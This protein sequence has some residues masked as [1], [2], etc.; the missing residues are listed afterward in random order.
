VANTACSAGIW[1]TGLAFAFLLVS[2]IV[3]AQAQQATKYKVLHAFT[4]GN[5]GG[6]LWGSLLLDERGDIYGTTIAGGTKGKGGTAFKLTRGANGTWKETVLYNFCSL[7]GCADGGGSFAGLI[8]DGAGNLYGTTESG[9]AHVYGTVFRL[10]PSADGWKETLLHSFG[11]NKYGCCPQASLVM[12]SAGNLF[13]TASVAFELS[14]G[15]DGWKETV[16][17]DFTGQNGDGSGAYTGLVLDAAGNLYGVTLHGGGG[18]C[19]GGCGTAYQLQPTTGGGWEEHILH[20]FDTG[21]DTMAFPDGPLLPGSIGNL[22]G[23]A[24]VGGATGNGTVYRLTL[25]SDGHWKA[26][27]LHS[28]TGG[29]NGI[30][31]AAG[32]VMDKAGNLYG[33]TNAGGTTACGCGLI[34]KLAPNSNGKWT[35]TVLHR[36]TGFDGAGPNANLIMDSKGSLYGTTTTGGAGGN[37]VA[38]ELA[39]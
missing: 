3:P 32:V 6:G 5:D 28:F 8:F 20:D 11:F 35:Y 22:Y 4:G 12:D 16:L 2:A 7:P 39:P 1:R 9:G 21:G 15:G 24:S 14:T 26:T 23:T 13:G 38:F 18:G 27:I 36:F 19:G 30:E 34:Y 25:E 33:T 17:H 37:G 31:P 10:T 29:A